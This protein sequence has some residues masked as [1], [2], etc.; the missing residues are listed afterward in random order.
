M[1][2]LLRPALAGISVAAMLAAIA[3]APAQKPASTP[4]GYAP[5][6]KVLKARCVGCHNGP[7]GRAGVNLAGYDAVLKGKWR[8]K[9]L[10]VAKKPGDSVLVNAVHGKGMQTMPPGGG[11]PS[12]DMKAIEAWIA[13]GAKK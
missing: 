10:V 4:S 6:K 7:G 5:V 8:G 1:K 13:A 12:A 3:V 11:L 9:A 2:S